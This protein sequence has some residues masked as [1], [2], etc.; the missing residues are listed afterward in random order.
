MALVHAKAT[1]ISDLDATPVKRAEAGRG[2]AGVLQYNEAT[3]L[4]AGQ[5][6][7]LSTYSLF[8][9]RSNIC[10]KFLELFCPDT[11]TTGS[12]DVGAFYG[13]NGPAGKTVDPPT[14]AGVS[15]IDLDF[16]LQAAVTSGTGGTYVKTVPGGGY[17]IPAGTVALVAGGGGWTV[18]QANL[19]LWKALAIGLT[20]LGT[21]NAG[22]PNCD[23]DIIASAH[24][25]F[26]TGAVT[27]WAAIGYV[28]P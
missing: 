2:A 6:D 11:G 22:D 4:I 9:V 26:D 7:I 14:T 27:I 25:A 23:I 18:A 17:V 16:F 21:A 12:L 15:L 19:P 28:T 3:V 5:A 10:L 13:P 24:A 20:V 1:A 8:R